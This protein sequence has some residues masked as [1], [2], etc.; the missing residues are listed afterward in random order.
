MR[1]MAREKRRW[2]EWTKVKGDSGY[3]LLINPQLHTP[4]GSDAM[5]EKRLT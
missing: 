5:E 4:E 3:H 2:A 1:C